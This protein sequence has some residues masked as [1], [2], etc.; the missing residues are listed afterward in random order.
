MAFGLLLIILKDFLENKFYDSLSISNEFKEKL[1][2]EIPSLKKISNSKSLSEQ[3]DYFLNSDFKN[4][5]SE[6]KKIN[7]FL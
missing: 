3:I 5:D 6:I 4:D 7:S 2:A 1:I